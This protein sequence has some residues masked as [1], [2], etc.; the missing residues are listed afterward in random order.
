LVV[1]PVGVGG[2]VTIYTQ[3]GGHLIAD[4]FGYFVLS[5]PTV[6]GRY[7]PL[8][9]VRLSDTRSGQSL[10]ISNPGDV[11]NCSDFATWSDANRYF[12]YYR[13]L[14]GD[15]AGLDGDNNLIPCESQFPSTR[16]STPQKPA[17]P[18]KSLAGVPFRIP[19]LN[20]YV[21]GTASAVALNVTSAD[22]APGYAQIVPTNGPTALGAS[23]NLNVSRA[24]DAMANLVIVP[25][26][27][28]GTVT[29]YTETPMHIIVDVQGFFTGPTSV[30]GTSGLFVPLRPSRLLDT[31]SG[32]G[33]PAAKVDANS[34]V[35]LPVRGTGG[36]PPTGVSAAMMNI[37]AT[38]ATA[39]GFVHVFPTGQATPGSSSNLNV[40]V[41][42]QTIPNAAVATIYSFG[43]TVYTSAG[44]HLLADI[45]GYFIE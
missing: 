44:A 41:A 19:I 35:S 30:G 42:G 34:S 8:V 23:S 26:G 9:P 6:D 15:V 22:G 21:P 2:K 40:S 13:D 39:P 43:M 16:P 33:A 37:T 36:A 18:M 11:K 12:W 7:T 45:S 29:I 17:D 32:I 3:G 20:T 1:V 31:R 38:Q 24:G 27:A 25:V 5:G 28:D 4:V 14:Y 10:L